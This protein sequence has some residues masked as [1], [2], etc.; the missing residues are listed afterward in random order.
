MVPVHGQLCTILFS[1]KYWPFD[2]H[3]ISF[4]DGLIDCQDPD[5]CSYPECINNHLCL[6]M[7]DPKSSQSTRISSKSSTSF[8]ERIR[9]LVSD[10]GIQRYAQLNSFDRQ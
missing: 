2:G 8:W 1:I 4:L 5:C 3:F 7:E 10:S 6:T 9:F